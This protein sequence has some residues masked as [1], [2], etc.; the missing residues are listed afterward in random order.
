MIII[1]PYLIIQLLALLLVIIVTLLFLIA[2]IL[3]INKIFQDYVKAME[4]MKVLK[5]EI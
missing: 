4:K 3:I 2:Q 5:K 1:I